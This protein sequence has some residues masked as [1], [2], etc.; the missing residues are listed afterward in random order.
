MFIKHSIKTDKKTAIQYKYL[1]LCESYRIGNKTRHRS[2][3]TLGVV[4]PL[5]TREK[6]KDF[7]DRIEQLLTG[8][9]LIFFNPLS[10]EIEALAQKF[11][12]KIKEQKIVR[13]NQS[14]ISAQPAEEKDFDTIDLNSL[15]TEDVKELGS[16]WLCYQA[17]EQ[18]GIRKFLEQQGWNK[19]WIDI[20]LIHL[21]SKAVY[22]ASEHKTEQWIEENSSVAELFSVESLTL[23][24]H[25]LYEASRMLYRVKDKLEPFLSS[26]TNELFDLQ[27]KIILY[28][29]TNTYFEGR[30]TGSALAQFGRSKE[31][32]SDAKLIALALVTNAAG[33][34]KYSKIY[35]GNMAD[36]KT[37]ETTVT[38]LSAATS[39][40]DRKP[41]VVIDAGIATDDNLK[42]LK[43]KG[44]QYL[45]V[46]RSKLKEYNLVNP[47][48]E[49][50]KL[51]DKRDNL[52]EV[53]R[54]EKE[55]N[56]DAFLYVRSVQKAKKETSMSSHFSIRFEEELDTLSSG[57]SKKGTTK[58]SEKVWE[59]IGRIKERYP[60]ANKCYTIDVQ[61]KDAIA[62]SV[63][64]SRKNTGTKNTDGVYFLRCS[65]PHLDEKSLWNIYTTLTEIEATFRTLKTDLNLRPVYHQKD[66]N[67][68]AHIFLGILAYSIV[69][70]IRYQLKQKNIHHD[71]SNIVRKMNTQK[72]VTTAMMNEKGKKILIKT[73]SIPTPDVIEI[74]EA[75]NYKK[76]PFTRKK[77]VFPENK[78]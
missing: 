39:Q 6:Q 45:C 31:K 68:E 44:H 74:Y 2:I 17:V 3:L 59:R 78:N 65:Q 36:C 12:K 20:A 16:E 24:R 48:Q 51:Y 50:I 21:I 27:D 60:S 10:N 57:L 18:L 53:Q 56:P 75:L 66:I 46:T 7:A 62:T 63:K 54:I 37:L 61:S 76:R 72:N 29:L 42:M 15:E 34:V 30:K 70:T 22:P 38:E 52:I 1:R 69:A 5:D 23:N 8:S 47:D 49:P 55:N 71:W 41:L 19:N 35:K 43:E 77:F 26:K 67:S 13:S 25:H 28:D 64:W 9:T 32:R 33:F 73:C 4:P 11:Y 40:Q 58:K 14:P